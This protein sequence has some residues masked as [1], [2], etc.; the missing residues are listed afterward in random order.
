MTNPDSAGS[1][2][3]ASTPTAYDDLLERYRRATYLSDA[4][5]VLSW[6]QEVMMPEGGTPARSKQRG[7]VSAVAHDVLVD[8]ET[9]DALDALDG[10][11]LTDDEAAVVR[12]IRREHERKARVPTELVEEI[13]TATSEAHPVWN[14]AKAAD[15]FDAFAPTLAE[16][17]DLKRRYAEH[18][19]PDA[20]PYATLFAEYE[21]Y[22]D[23]STAERV[24]EELRDGLVPLIDAIGASDTELYALEGTFPEDDQFAV[25][26]AALETLGYDFEHGRLDTAPHP[27]STGTQFDARVT[28]RFDESEPLDSLASTIH[29]FGHATY[30]LG[31]PR[32]AYGSPLGEHRGLSVHE[33]QSR[34]FENHVG[35]SK[36]FWELFV[37]RFND[38]HDTELTPQQAY[39]AAN[40]VYDDNLI[41]VE[42]DE[43][44]YHLHIVLRF[45]IEREL[46]AG[47]LDVE[48]VPA[49]WND[50]ME[51][52]LGVRP[53][54][55][56]EGCLQDIHWS[57]GSFGYFPTYSLGSVL[58]AQL[59][60]AADEAIDGLESQI[61][62]GEFDALHEWLTENIHQHGRR[63]TT[64]DVIERATGE[65]LTADYFLEY[66]EAKFGELYDL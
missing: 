13:S 38:H 30:T 46:L 42:A 34:L 64:G 55:D 49:A 50:R 40:R 27:F 60:A 19:D 28:T 62:A 47:D 63:Y 1:D 3:D 36:P 11:D 57:H 12:E 16:L 51:S 29:E 58:A 18:I 10:V 24:L 66:A 53:E 14:E 2:A 44:T 56:A 33:S 59:Y 23:L 61:A 43:L 5:G 65:P 22:L 31:L 25:T 17:L 48:E 45:E 7:A 4:N 15:D 6:D 8:E 39:E 54:T 9:A 20:D 52:Y 35:R 41:R 26:E 37:D 21:P 32:D